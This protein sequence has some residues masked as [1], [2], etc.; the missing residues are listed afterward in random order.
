LVTEPGYR[1]VNTQIAE[2]AMAED[3][4]KTAG[5]A[6]APNAPSKKIPHV[7]SP[8]LSPAAG[9]SPS[10]ADTNAL[11]E[12]VTVPPQ[13]PAFM[14]PGYHAQVRRRRSATLA[15]SVSAAV[16]LGV[17]AGM[18]M[19]AVLVAPANNAPA[20]LAERQAMQQSIE[21]LS[22]DLAALQARVAAAEPAAAP[23]AKTRER[24]SDSADI[25]GSIPLP[26]TDAPLPQPRPATSRSHVVRG[27]S[28]RYVRDGFVYVQGHGGIY[29]VQ[30]GAPLPGLGPVQDVQRRDGRWAVLTPKG[31][32]IS[33]HDRP[34][35]ERF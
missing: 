30:L 15:A 24:F 35:F 7:P 3:S 12:I 32:I 21:T 26:V 2:R 17:V 25:T 5:K 14:R 28:I 10:L 31:L 27:W 33:L 13:V 16:M 1:F 34:H 22:Q 6:P 20:R 19:G 23:V 9:T 29:Q 11:P 18:A 4:D 8:P